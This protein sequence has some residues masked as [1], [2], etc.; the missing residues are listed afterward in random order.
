[1]NNA[2][3]G[4]ECGSEPGTGRLFLA[5][6]GFAFLSVIRAVAPMPRGRPGRDVGMPARSVTRHLAMLGR[7]RALRSCQGWHQSRSTRLPA[8]CHNA[9]LDRDRDH[10]ARFASGSAGG[11]TAGSDS[12]AQGSPGR[13]HRSGDALPEIFRA[14]SRWPTWCSGLRPTGNGFW[15]SPR[16]VRVCTTRQRAR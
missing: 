15:V 1:M 9:H 4:D 14:T 12:A 5:R 16:S 11:P 10:R 2:G 7:H 3:V 6:T 13:G 8:L